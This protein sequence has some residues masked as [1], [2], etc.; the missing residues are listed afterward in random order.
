VFQIA[1]GSRRRPVEPVTRWRLELRGDAERVVV[2]WRSPEVSLAI[3]ET[4][5]RVGPRLLAGLRDQLATR[6]CAQLGPLGLRAEAV[7][8]KAK[9]P[10][11]REAVEAIEIAD[12]IPLRLRILRSGRALPYAS[13]PLDRVPNVM[14][15]LDL[16]AELG[17]PVRGRELVPAHM[18][19][20]P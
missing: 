19:T 13:T 5:R 12:W 20:Q 1:R 11:P 15:A 8:W 17:F 4:L 10:L 2:D 3:S 18:A 14:A 6:C 9:E 7:A 16:A